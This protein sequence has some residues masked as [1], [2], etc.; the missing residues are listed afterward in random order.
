MRSYLH[1]VDQ[2]QRREYYTILKKSQILKTVG[3]QYRVCMATM[4]DGTS[5]EVYIFLL[6]NIFRSP[7]RNCILPAIQHGCHANSPQKII[8]KRKRCRLRRLSRGKKK[9]G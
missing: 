3:L 8:M 9:I 2:T 4:L 5:N 6:E 1:I 7:E